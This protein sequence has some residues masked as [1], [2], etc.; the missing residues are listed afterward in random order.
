[1]L[2]A[3]LAHRAPVAAPELAGHE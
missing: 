3:S 1:Q 2:R